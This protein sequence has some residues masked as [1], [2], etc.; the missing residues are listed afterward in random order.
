MLR[1]RAAVV[2]AVGVAFSEVALSQGYGGPSMLSRGGNRP[3]QRGRAPAEIIVYGGVRGTVD[4]GLVP[5][6]LEE[7]GTLANRTIYG[8]QA[9][10]GAYGTHSWRRTVLGLDYRGDYRM[11]TRNSGFNGTNQ[12]LSLDI[13]HQMNSR[14][15]FFFRETAGTTNRA[16]G[17]FAAPVHTDLSSLNLANDEAF[18]TRVYFSQTSGGVAIR[19]S[20]RM[21]V[22][23]SGD[24]FFVKRPDPRL[25]STNGF[26]ATG[27]VNYRTSSRTMIG[28]A[29]QFLNFEYPRAY[30]GSELHGPM[31]TVTHRL[32][33]NLELSIAAG[34]L[35]VYTFGTQNVTL[36]PEVAALLG[37]T[38]GV[39]A[40]TRNDVLPQ[41]FASAGYTLERSR[42]TASFLSG[43]TP[44]NGVL[45]TSQ[46][47]AGMLG[48]SFTGIRKLSLGASARYAQTLSK[49]IAADKLSN[50]SVG[51]GINY[52]IT[53]LLNISSQL[54][55]R[56]YRTGGISGREGFAFTLG[57]IVSPA[58]I[59]VSIW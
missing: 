14:L 56:T 25:V 18:D 36:S 45:L 47:N 48:Y 49:S 9:E 42:F 4:T 27:A 22:V 44:G 40:F 38:S 15:N 46:R 34:L 12:A 17:G 50:T 54:D 43:T 32:T 19:K 29:Y 8:G 37:R 28:G 5:V 10:I 7:D 21:T 30:G 59:P 55:Y 6:L 53:R 23:L 13:Q 39:E 16:F 33:R 2:L 20:A 31:F 35:L 58:R 3:G 24:G 41:I 51:G 52:A 11:T 1:R 57:L 26:R